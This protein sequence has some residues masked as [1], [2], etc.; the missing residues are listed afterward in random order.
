MDAKHKLIVHHEVTNDGNDAEQLARQAMA[1]KEVLGVD[2]LIVEADAGFYSEAQLAECAEANITAYVAI[3][4]KYRA[5]SAEER[6]SGAQF[7]YLPQVDA[8][9]CPGGQLLRP[10]GKPALRRGVERT[11]YTCPAS[12]CKGCPLKAACLP[13]RTPHRQIWRSEHAEVAEAHR[14][15]MAAEGRER[16]VQRASVV[17]HPFGTLKRWFGWDHF[18]VRGFKKVRGEMAL[19]VLGYNLTR[20]I[21]I[22]G[23]QAFRDYCAQRLTGGQ[24]AAQA[25]VAA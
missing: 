16:M 15:R 2:R 17:E 13:K 24:M 7:P 8:Y 23:L 3:P 12:Q 22:L 20:V 10:Q 4:D 1:A 11:R 25:A 14:Q 6:F 18:L 19:M 5:V 21:N 9:I